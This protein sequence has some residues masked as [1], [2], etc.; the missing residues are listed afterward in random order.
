MKIRTKNVDFS[1]LEKVKKPK[2]KKPQRPW[3]ILGVLINI[4][5][6][7][8]LRAT[9]FKYKKENMEKAG[10]GPYLILMNHSSFIDLEIAYRIFFPK[11]FG[12][13]CTSDSF[14]GLSFILRKLG[15]I[16]TNKFVSDIG[17]VSDMLYSVK[18]NKVSVLMYPEASYTFDGTATTLPQK[19]G[20]LAK[21]MDVPIVMVKTKG[22]F[23]R[24]PLYNCLKKRKVN[25]SATVK[26][27]FS[28]DEVRTLP[29]EEITSAI[30]NEFKFDNF[31]EQYDEKIVINEEFRADGLERILYR[32]PECL[33]EEGMEGKGTQ[34]VCKKCGKA[35]E[36]D[37]LGQLKALTD[38]TKF[39][40]IPDWYAWQRECVK[41]EIES[42]EYRLDCDVKI[43][44]LADYKAIYMVGD[45]H[46]THTK[47]GFTL[48]GCD[49]RLSYT[50][51]SSSSYG[52]YA[53]YYWYQIDD[54]ICIG[55]KKRLYYCFPK[56]K[57]NVA[58]ARLAAEEIYK[59]KIN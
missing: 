34:L 17:L 38:D 5:S 40:H 43:G 2:R 49:G 32:C 23:L 15:C 37:T 41:K 3:W 56:E 44:V 46:L 1:Y 10:K 29:A 28:L 16:P 8:D 57:V 25:V 59:L 55:D 7:F 27:L 47:D 14:V 4:I 12:F 11:K 31:K 51:K 53:D 39:S 35:Y 13:V 42:G 22:A 26:C 19:L 18:K 9:R 33:S 48:N 6:F 54:V 20:V 58:K 50:Q 24:Q 45:G 36:M 52:L 30:E 21:K